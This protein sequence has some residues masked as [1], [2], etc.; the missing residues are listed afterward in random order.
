MPPASSAGLTIRLPDDNLA[1]LFLRE[2]LAR[3]RL[4]E[5]VVALMLVF[6]T[7]DILLFLLELE[8][9][10]DPSSCRVVCLA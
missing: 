10:L 7:I 6:T 9:R 2:S 1:K 8:L 4:S 3:D 5:A